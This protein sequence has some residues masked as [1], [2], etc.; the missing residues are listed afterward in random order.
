MCQ[1]GALL[2]GSTEDGLIPIIWR[3]NIN[4]VQLASNFFGIG[5]GKDSTQSS[6]NFTIRG[7][8]P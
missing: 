6:F 7:F 1:I 5:T 3:S 8:W 4:S 2:S